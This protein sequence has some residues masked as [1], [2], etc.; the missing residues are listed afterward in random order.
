MIMFHLKDTLASFCFAP[1]LL[2]HPSLNPLRT[3]PSPQK[4]DFD[5]ATANERDKAA[6]QYM[7]ELKLKNSGSKDDTVVGGTD[8]HEDSGEDSDLEEEAADSHE[9][10]EEEFYL[11]DKYGFIIEDIDGATGTSGGSRTTKA[12]I[13]E[14]ERQ[15]RAD[16]ESSRSI[17]W[18]AMI[19][20]WNKYR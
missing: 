6:E 13:S 14:K 17:K 8:S 18:V 10:Q 20:E 15:K 16:L 2:S 5:K 12:L 3:P 19:S 7:L 4:S 9:T 1:P 11:V